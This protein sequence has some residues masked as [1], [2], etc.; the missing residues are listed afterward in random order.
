M[1]YVFLAWKFVNKTPK[2]DIPSHNTARIQCFK[3]L[4]S[5]CKMSLEQMKDKLNHDQCKMYENR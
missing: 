1:E 2:W 4:S 5:M 3:S